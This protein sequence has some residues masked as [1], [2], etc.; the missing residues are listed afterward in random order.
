MNTEQP[1]ENV[2]T[3]TI[4]QNPHRYPPSFGNTQKNSKAEPQKSEHKW[5]TDKEIVIKPHGSFLLR[6]GMES[7]RVSI[8]DK[9]FSTE[10][11]YKAGTALWAKIEFSAGS[12]PRLLQLM[13][14]DV[15]D[16]LSGIDENVLNRML[17]KLSESPER[18]RHEI[19]Q[20]R[21]NRKTQ[22]EDMRA[23]EIGE[24]LFFLTY[25]LSK[26]TENVVKHTFV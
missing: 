7:F 18:L 1:N 13:E 26:H 20:R 8:P 4:R 12:N 2:I 25:L 21:F 22:K 16:R 17:D 11:Q 10:T 14:A 3:G 6:K 24:D 15:H 9:F 19:L 23:L 5:S